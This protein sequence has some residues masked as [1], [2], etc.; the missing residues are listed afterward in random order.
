MEFSFEIEVNLIL[1]THAMLDE[2]VRSVYLVSRKSQGSNR[3]MTEP[4]VSRSLPSGGH[5]P[6]V[7]ST[8]LLWGSWG[9]RAVA[10][11]VG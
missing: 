1:V 11:E 9:P 8:S 7:R 5:K 2:R 6:H 10:L 4:L 3:H